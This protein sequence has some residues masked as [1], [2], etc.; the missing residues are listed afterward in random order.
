MLNRCTPARAVPACAE[1][2]RRLS[3]RVSRAVLRGVEP[4]FGELWAAAGAEPSTPPVTLAS[5]P[6]GR[7]L[8]ASRGLKR[9]ELVVSIPLSVCLL[10]QDGEAEGGPSEA[11]L[12]RSL[13]AVVADA[14]SFWHGYQHLLP[15]MTG[16]VSL[17]P[18]SSVDELQWPAAVDAAQGA[19]LHWRGLAARMGSGERALWA[20]SMVHSRSFAVN[21]PDSGRLRVL[22]PLCDLVNNEQPSATEAACA[23]EDDEVMPWR[24]QDGRFELRAVRDFSAGDEVVMYYGHETSLELLMSYGFI[25]S[26]N[27][28]DHVVLYADIE[29]LLDDDRWTPPET[30]RTRREKAAMLRGADAAAAPLAVRPGGLPAMAHLLGCLRVMHCPASQLS[31]LEERFDAAVGHAVWHWCEGDAELQR[32]VDADALAQACARAR[33]LLE[34]LPTTLEEDL[35]SM[36]QELQVNGVQALRYRMEVKKLLLSLANSTRTSRGGV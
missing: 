12:A 34:E 5:T 16:A 2:R 7:G 31:R 35:A 27:P 9:G 14:E 30:P 20:L 24:V 4:G 21:L 32:T 6:L 13:L 36:E 19:R 3:R 29:E 25:P 17:W 15:T 10:V 18:A 8:V 26:P 28:V 11:R 22:A 33:E 23:G 1:C